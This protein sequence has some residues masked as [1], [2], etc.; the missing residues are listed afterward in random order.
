[1]LILVSDH[2]VGAELTFCILVFFSHISGI[3]HPLTRPRLHGAFY[4][5]RALVK[6][7]QIVDCEPYVINSKWKGQSG[8]AFT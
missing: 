6:Y 8:R 7:V 4:A 5:R 2:N 3:L 1:M